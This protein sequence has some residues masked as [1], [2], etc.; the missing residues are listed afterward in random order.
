MFLCDFVQSVENLEAALIVEVFGYISSARP[1]RNVAFRPVL[2]GQKSSG[3]GKVVDDAEPFLRA[4]MFEVTLE[5]RSFHE[6]I[7]RLKRLITGQTCFVADLER[8]CQSVRCEVG[9]ADES[10]LPLLDEIRVSP[11]GF[12]LRR[13]RIIGMRLVEI[14]VAGLQAS[15]GIFGGAKY[16]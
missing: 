15:Q 9:S 11:Q 16:V 10:D 3:Q 8:R 12:F 14:D 13:I 6:A 2:A 5:T 1:A 7:V 4:E